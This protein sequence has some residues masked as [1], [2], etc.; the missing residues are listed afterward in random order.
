[1]HPGAILK[2]F[3]KV[4]N[5]DKHGRNIVN[6]TASTENFTDVDLELDSG[7]TTTGYFYWNPQTY[8]YI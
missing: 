4:I 7:I 2:S 1:M 6:A 8:S 5:F 3:I